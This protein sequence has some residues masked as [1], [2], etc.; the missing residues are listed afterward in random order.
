M[1]D[2]LRGFG[3][4]NKSKGMLGIVA[5]FSVFIGV[6]VSESAIIVETVAGTGIP[7]SVDGMKGSAQLNYPTALAVG[8]QSEL[9]IADTINSR[10]RVLHPDG[11]VST[12]YG[13][14]TTQF[15]PDIIKKNGVKPTLPPLKYPY[16]LTVG[17]DGT[18][19]ISDTGN[20]RIFQINSFQHMSVLAGSGT[21]GKINGSYLK[22]S[23]SSPTGIVSDS[24]GNIYVADTNNHQ[25]R[26][27][28]KGQVWTFAGNSKNASTGGFKDGKGTSASFAFPT[29]LAIDRFDNIYVADTNNHAIRKITPQGVVTTLAGTGTPGSANG[30]GTQASFTYPSGLSVDFY[31]NIY[32]TEFQGHRVR[33]IDTSG[34]VTS[35]AGTGS[36]GFA[37]GSLQDA[38]FNYPYGIISDGRGALWIADAANNRV[39]LYR[40]E[41]IR[42]QGAMGPAA[43]TPTLSEWGMILLFSF[44]LVSLYRKNRRYKLEQN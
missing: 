34:V 43:T 13:Y 22:A 10:I 9:Y 36:A 37:D 21:K 15:K 17:A 24:K 8:K 31:G 41:G 12:V 33:K 14:D 35:V 25:I 39:R 44:L 11:Q 40:E 30:A 23:F 28:S 2:L 42:I 3:K 20:N 32:V 26:I 4:R 18:L 7:G 5:L 1:R 27:I 16:G 38:R 29:G 19:Y 6:H